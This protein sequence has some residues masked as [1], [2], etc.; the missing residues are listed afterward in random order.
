MMV[1]YRMNIFEEPHNIFGGSR[2]GV[3]FVKKMMRLTKN[4]HNGVYRKPPHIPFNYSARDDEDWSEFIQKHFGRDGAEIKKYKRPPPRVKSDEDKEYDE[5][6][7]WSYWGL[8]KDDLDYDERQKKWWIGDTGYSFPPVHWKAP[9]GKSYW[10]LPHYEDKAKGTHFDKIA[11]PMDNYPQTKGEFS[12]KYAMDKKEGETSHTYDEVEF[13][14]KTFRVEDGV[15]SHARDWAG[16]RPRY[17]YWVKGGTGTDRYNQAYSYKYIIPKTGQPNTWSRTIIGERGEKQLEDD[18]PPD[19]PKD[20]AE[21][22]EAVKQIKTAVNEIKHRI[23]TNGDLNFVAFQKSERYS[24]AL[25]KAKDVVAYREAVKDYGSGWAFLSK[26]RQDEE[27]RKM[28][29]ILDARNGD[30]FKEKA[31]PMN[32][33]VGGKSFA[34]LENYID[35]WDTLAGMYNETVS[36]YLDLMD[37]NIE[38]IEEY[39]GEEDDSVE[40]KK[41]HRELLYNA[42]FNDHA[43]DEK[44]VYR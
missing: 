4:K 6:H 44:P 7:K 18:P 38:L 10:G 11:F 2:K 21:K 8:D 13:G 12:R 22:E 30:G 27:E 23:R 41:T 26:T 43:R 40:S 28:Y 14:D 16:R 5:V 1:E 31:F 33:G 35:H 9:N 20:D 32:S 25:S 3:A 39:G 24:D 34:Q 36:F 37:K 15:V 42:N 29:D 17:Y 19:E